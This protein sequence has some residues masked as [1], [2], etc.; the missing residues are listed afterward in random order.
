MRWM[1][2]GVLVMGCSGLPEKPEVPHGYYALTDQF[3]TIDAPALYGKPLRVRFKEAGNGPPLFL[4]HGLQTS[5]YS[6]RYN[7]DE[8][9]KT[10]HVIA[11]DLV[12]SGMTSHPDD[13][14]YS[15][16]HVADFVETFR[17]ELEK[18]DPKFAKVDLVGNS[19]G[20]AYS[21]VYAVRHPDRV[22][23]LIV[24]HAPAFIDKAPFFGLEQMRRGRVPRFMATVLFGPWMIKEYLRYHRPGMMSQEDV[25]EYSRPF[26]DGE[27]RRAFWQIVT[28]GISPEVSDR[29]TPLLAQVK[30]P[31]LLIWATHDTL[32]PPWTGHR[33]NQA[34][35]G[36][37]L[38]WIQESSHF[39]HVEAPETTMKL[40]NEFLAREP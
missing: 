31:T 35:A 7:I 25:T 28:E 1:L 4:V 5:S 30:K 20:G 34:I 37:E 15:P 11:M 27:G 19:L 18:R 16:E 14:G 9:G 24:I 12:G 21:S 10:H 26:D 22:R 40:I 8:L 36:S 23:K 33:W 38:V 2:L 29:L 3:V 17:A 6:W 39:P 32:I 13:F